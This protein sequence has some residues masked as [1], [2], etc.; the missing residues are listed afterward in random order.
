MKHILLGQMQIFISPSHFWTKAHTPFCSIPHLNLEIAK[1]ENKL[2]CNFRLHKCLWSSDRKE[3]LVYGLQKLRLL[4]ILKQRTAGKPTERAELLH[5]WLPEGSCSGLQE[6][7][8]K[9]VVT[10]KKQEG[11]G[12]F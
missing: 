4:M 1:Q 2:G 7:S 6:W 8:K 12:L 11:N 5:K 3:K 9:G 10:T